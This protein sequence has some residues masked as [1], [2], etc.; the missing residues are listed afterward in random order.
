MRLLTYTLR[1]LLVLVPIIIF[2]V[3]MVFFLSRVIPADPISVSAGP[4]ATQEQL[5]KLAREWGLDKPL[6]VQF[7]LYLNRLLHGDWGV[8]IQT[9]RPVMEDLKVFFPATFGLHQPR[10][11]GAQSLWSE[12]QGDLFRLFF[13]FHRRGD[14]RCVLSELR[15]GGLLLGHRS[16]YEQMVHTR[17]HGLSRLQCCP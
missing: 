2:V 12:A 7:V 14:R 11:A 6:I 5:D 10:L 3:F 15:C 9:R 13:Q 8:S 16:R 1:R 17:R 4:E